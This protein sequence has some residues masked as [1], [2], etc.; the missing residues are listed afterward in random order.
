MKTFRTFGSGGKD[1]SQ[2]KSISSV[3][4]KLQELNNSTSE[5]NHSITYTFLKASTHPSPLREM[6]ISQGTMC[7]HCVLQLK[8]FAPVMSHRL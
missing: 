5:S 7:T 6:S 8:N 1:K 2:N 4:C 3:I